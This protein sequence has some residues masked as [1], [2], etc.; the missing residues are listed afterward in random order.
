MEG[1]VVRLVAELSAQN[2]VAPP[3]DHIQGNT[4]S[5]QPFEN[6]PSRRDT[7]RTQQPAAAEIPDSLPT[8]NG[9][10]LDRASWLRNLSNCA[11]MFEADL[12]YLLH[13]GCGLTSSFTA[14]ISPEHSALLN[15][16]YIQKQQFGVMNPPP[17]ADCFKDLYAR[18]SAALIIA[19]A[20]AASGPLDAAA[21]AALPAI[22][23]PVLP[24]NHKLSPDR[25]L[26][27]D[28]KLRNVILGL[29]A[30]TGR[31]RHYQDLTQSGCEL[32]R[33]LIEEAKPSKTDY[34][35]SPHIL[36]L[37]SQLASLK[38]LTLSHISQVEFDEIRDAI[39]EINVQLDIDDQMTDNQLC[40]HYTGL[41]E[42][43]DSSPLWL[44]LQVELRTNGHDYG[45]VDE[46]IKCITKVLTVFI[47]RD[48]R[49]NDKAAAQR[50]LMTNPDRN[51]R[52]PTKGGLQKERSIPNKP[53]NLCGKLH[54]HSQCF[55][56]PKCDEETKKLALRV[57]PRS[58][59]A[60]GIKP[61]SKPPSTAPVP[62]NTMKDDAPNI[63]PEEAASLTVQHQAEDE[64]IAAA[65]DNSS[66]QAILLGQANMAALSAFTDADDYL[67][68][69]WSDLEDTLDQQKERHLETLEDY[70]TSSRHIGAARVAEA[71]P[72]ATCT[73]P[74]TAPASSNL[75]Y[76]T[77]LPHQVFI[78][79][80]PTSPRPPEP[81][82][83][84]CPSTA[85]CPQRNR[86]CYLAFLTLLVAIL[87][88]TVSS[89]LTLHLA[90][91]TSSEYADAGQPCLPFIALTYASSALATASRMIASSATTLFRPVSACLCLLL[92]IPSLYTLGRVISVLLS[93]FQA[94]LGSA[95]QSQ[96][97]NNVFT[98]LLDANL[99]HSRSGITTAML[100]P[101]TYLLSLP[102]VLL[103][104][105]IL[106]PLASVIGLHAPTH[107]RAAD[108]RRAHFILVS[109][110]IQTTRPLALPRILA[111]SVTA[112]AVLA[113]TFDASFPTNGSPLQPHS[114][115]LIAAAAL[116]VATRDFPGAGPTVIPPCPTNSNREPTPLSPRALLSRKGATKVN[117]R[118]LCQLSL[119]IDSGA[120]F[121]IHP[122]LDDLVN[123]RSCS[124][125]ILGVGQAPHQCTAIGDLP[126]RARASDGTE[127]NLILRNVRYVSTF[128]DTLISVGQLWQDS[129]V[130]TVFKDC[131][132]L[133]LPCGLR[134]PFSKAKGAGLYTWRVS[135]IRPRFVDRRLVTPRATPASPSPRSSEPPP[136]PHHPAKAQRRALSFHTRSSKSIAHIASLHPDVAA[137]Y[138]HRRLHV[139]TR[140]MNLLPKLTEDAPE[141]LTRAKIGSCP[142]CVVSNATRLQHKET[143]YEESTPGRLIHADVAGPFTPSAVGHHKYLLVLVDD[144][145]RFKFVFPL[146]ERSDAPAKIRGF[147]ASFNA[148]S[149]RT[150]STVQRI[151]TL[152]T[153]GA[154]EFTSG[155]FRDELADSLVHKT[156]S[157]PEVH[158]L[159]GVAERAIRAIFAHVRADL[160][161]SGAPRSFW[162]YAAAQACDVLNRTTCPPHGRHSCYEA[163]TGDKP[164]V[165]GIW[166]WGCRA[167]GV[168]P[169]AFRS[170]TNIDNTAWEGML[171][172]RSAAQ[173]GAYEIWLPNQHKVVSSSECYMQETYM[174]WR[175]PGDRYVSDPVPVP[176]DA[177]AGQPPSLPETDP[178]NIPEPSQ[179]RGSLSAEFERVVRSESRDG[180]LP[181]NANPARLSKRVLVLYSGPYSRPDGL[182]A[183]LR[184]LGVDVTALDNDG[185]N[186]GDPNHNILDD[187]VYESILRRVQR[188]EFLA[189]FAAPPCSTFSVS[190][191]M[192]SLHSSDGGP[193]V[194]RRRSDGQV[195][196]IKDCP[197]AHR[198]EL[199]RSND[200]VA[201]TCAILGAAL[202]VGTEF[203]MENPADSGDPNFP[204]RLIDPEHAPIWLMPE[205]V[206]LAK[207]AHC[208]FS[209]F[210]MCAFGVDYEKPTTIMYTPRLAS[211]LQDLDLLQCTH[212]GKHKGSAG[213]IKDQGV[214]NSA[215]AAAYPAE[216]N[217][218]IAQAFAQ[219]VEGHRD[220]PPHP[221]VAQRAAAPDTRLSFNADAAPS[222]RPSPHQPDLSARTTAPNAPIS[223]PTATPTRA[224]S[225]PR[226]TTPLGAIPE[227]PPRPPR[228]PRVAETPTQPTSSP[229]RPWW[230]TDR[231]DAVSTRT[232]GS[233]R[234]EAAEDSKPLLI[235]AARAVDET[236]LDSPQPVLMGP[237]SS[238]TPLKPLTGRALAAQSS[239]PP[240]SSP[241][242]PDPR[243]HAE[244]MLDD[245]E[246]WM[247]AEAAELNNHQ[248]NGSFSLMDRS[249]FEREAPGRRLVKLVW[250]YK[251]KR[252]G[253]MKARLCVQGCTQQPGVDFDQTHC[254][255]MRGTSLRLLS[256]LAGRHN[257]RMRRWDFVSAYLQGALEDGEV[258]YCHA[259]PGPHGTT[260]V[261]GKQRVWRVNKP[262]Y[263]MAQAGRR[264]QR[265]LFPWLK[266]WGLTACDSDPCVFFAR[267][268]VDT[269][270]GPRED[271]L[272]V[273]CYVDDLFVLSNSHDPH[274]LY[275]LFT[276]DLQRRWKVDDEGDVSDLLNVEILRVDGGVELRQT[277]Y[278]EKLIK[279]WLP[280]G[281]PSSI[282]A[283]STPHAE[284]LPDLV[285]N[286]L[287]ST[288]PVDHN[289]LGR[290][291]SLI[292]SLL[293]AASN[294][295]PDIAFAVG[296]L[297]RA[298]GKPSTDLFEAGLRV[299]AY[300][301]HHKAIGLRYEDDQRDLSGMSDASWAVQHSTSGHIF[302]MSK[303]AISWSSK[304]QPTIALS[305][306][307]SEI[308][309]ASEAAKEAVY[310]DRFVRELGFKSD[311]EPVRLSLDNKAAIDSSYNPENHSRTKHIERR[312]YFIRELVELNQLVVPFVSSVDNLADFFTKPIKPVRFFSLRDKIMNVPH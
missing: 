243:N 119:I 97:S 25:I 19:A 287:A 209:T 98:D 203:A 2:L 185:A 149:S 47:G 298:M 84:M 18:T 70:L 233:L 104:Y 24:D 299:L 85:R 255:A 35:Q 226:I 137:R 69:N 77:S 214:W 39:E 10:L 194:I 249:D 42:G 176:A 123:I 278:I 303:A 268:Q 312:H 272:I 154:G 218:L 27:L 170:K 71:V 54:W 32:L 96:K 107:D 172:G 202:D 17:I 275:H 210:A 55:Q 286:A 1:R 196:G 86:N 140:R 180:A 130:D 153:D 244:A 174:P 38:T 164:R 66:P 262:V 91:P 237:D 294:T 271:T 208:R 213:G 105:F 126:I 83:P 114:Q 198:R 81:K 306:C 207:R 45:D 145:S 134:F 186:G 222:T 291:Q 310:L 280:D 168:K 163:L 142:H 67:E 232:R 311:N 12:A 156:E 264:W 155:K 223:L 59:A 304:K 31:K 108:Y 240:D 183:Y 182:I 115:P 219:L 200:V 34:I 63:G 53:C 241:P 192:H 95:H 246:G 161:A 127:R 144:S 68:D 270:Q 267:R 217:L 257:L 113:S 36:R 250:V 14:V 231:P 204:Q 61:T 76:S 220:I 181:P 283:N 285:L 197:A 265:T 75:N 289:L 187:K 273:G 122:H 166:P 221:L 227:S 51:R 43:L 11:H 239:K 292:G 195:T 259:P 188:G 73:R 229:R 211:G 148:F 26:L 177:D 169:S 74:V 199:K 8:T 28:L 40:D 101:F 93:I 23:S 190:R 109:R 178:A 236:D 297:C 41:I 106:C 20:R 103:L 175:K 301:S 173:P 90:S 128:T 191:F 139:G 129:S 282:H 82:E 276:R 49:A 57:A 160:E 78:S 147:I 131:C 162:P 13:T 99:Q 22:P 260:G 146:V 263:G 100:C 159:N 56:N 254:A 238:W 277:G 125:R 117:S 307:E 30:S 112:L 171:L 269:P 121:H 3:L 62:G 256:A 189:A 6:M 281:V 279:E 136:Q 79:A 293:Y 4:L 253:R 133:S 120:S 206:A 138:M 135:P 274:S 50:A 111:A 305:S 5:T 212:G 87:S 245:T 288:E 205:V 37:K 261:D 72:L 89:A 60:T 201:R 242:R 102:H 88:A 300:L 215:S 7:P 308:M 258:V 143:R 234:S 46:T 151:G 165:M 158:A 44:A 302:T 65:L 33:L 252:S 152:H 224:P 132:Y 235:N 157:P 21:A 124:T 48:E 296:M 193:P 118:S 110:R 141:N 284:N 295:R 230:F 247:E 179:R 15:Q 216:L 58:P 94:L 16:G 266:E 225:L 80:S 150:G 184:T 167:F 309:A 64:A 248:E 251:R 228:T 92:L 290:Y 29:I 52:D 116:I 9:T